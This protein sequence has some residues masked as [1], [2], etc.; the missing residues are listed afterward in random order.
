MT[1]LTKDAVTLYDIETNSTWR[2]MSVQDGEHEVQLCYGL[3]D[4]MQEYETT[5]R[6]GALLR[7]ILQ[8]D[9]PREYAKPDQGGVY[10]FPRSTTTSQPVTALPL[11]P[12]RLV[13]LLLAPAANPNGLHQQLANQ[14]GPRDARRLMA[15]AHHIA[16][17]R[18]WTDA[19]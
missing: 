5:D 2:T 17:E 8:I 19:S 11:D 15:A 3:G 4:Q 6:D 9:A 16:A 10:V 18:L 13:D 12:A 1:T 7:V 14:T